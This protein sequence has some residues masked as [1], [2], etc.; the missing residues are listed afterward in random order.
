MSA[1][2]RVW[3][4]LFALLLLSL[5]VLACGPDF[6]DRFLRSRMSLL[7]GAPR[8]DFARELSTITRGGASQRDPDADPR[9]ATREADL[10]DLASYPGGERLTA[11]YDRAR[12]AMATRSAPAPLPASLPREI[13]LYA[14]GARAFHEGRLD[15]ARAR[16]GELLALP[17]SARRA[18]STWAAFMLGRLSTGDD[19]VA[20]F[21]E[22]RRL[23]AAGF[24]DR[25]R[26]ATTARSEEA[27]VELARGNH[28]AAV[29]LYVSAHVAG[30]PSAAS[31]LRLSA[32]AVLDAPADART[33]AL[34]HPLTREL[35]ASYLASARRDELPSGGRSARARLEEVA[36]ALPP[37]GVVP[38]AER[39]AWLAYRLGDVRRA[40]E[41]LAR[42]P[43]DTLLG[44]W[45]A[46]KLA[47]RA[48]RKDEA[49]HA[50]GR[51]VAKL[52][53][54]TPS[55]ADVRESPLDPPSRARAELA[56]LRLDRGELVSALSLLLA[57]GSWRDAAH[58]A[59]RVMTVE[60]LTAFVDANTSPPSLAEPPREDPASQLRYLLARRLVR[61][62]RAATAMRYMPAEHR[63]S[64]AAWIKLERAASRE[65]GRARVEA[66]SS[67]ARLQRH[68]GME[69][70][71]TELAPDW[72]LDGG[73]FDEGA[74][75]LDGGSMVRPDERARYRASAPPRPGRFHYRRVAAE[76]MR[77][78]ADLSAGDEA[79]AMLCAAHRWL[80]DREP[81]AAA[82]YTRELRRR[83]LSVA[84]CD[85]ARAAELA[86]P[87]AQ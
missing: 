80:V 36:A 30:D 86:S 81:T 33:R 40:R 57:A 56:I 28:A 10:A 66:L 77:A 32:R 27:R 49:A 82:R 46:A 20:R 44:E 5:P 29:D 74:S 68:R 34:R 21:R 6:P 25:L 62:D 3:R 83:H 75:T 50:L 39:L 15:E 26:L 14:L 37:D 18:K 9:E 67:L 79:A 8:T 55:D 52:P 63:A 72:H 60:E 1:E 42:A 19:A 2:S 84:L 31:S 12:V 7:R 43:S 17:A 65:R 23:A 70:S 38:G 4:A 22:V 45:L 35:V 24:D 41:L 16:F 78:A 13:E 51:A 76:T 54:T 64:L 61:D 69:L 71:G 48:G 53:A 87:L 73:N 47:L 11:A 59:E 85:G 58:V